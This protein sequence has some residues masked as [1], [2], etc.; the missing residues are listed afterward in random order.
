MLFSCVLAFEVKLTEANSTLLSDDFGNLNNWTIING[1]WTNTDGV[2]QGTSV[3][4]GEGLIWAGNTAWTN[5]KVTANLQVVTSGEASLVVKYQGPANFYWLGLGCWGHK[6]SISKIVGGVYQELASSGLASEVDVG[7]WYLVSAVA[8]DNKLQLFVDGAK[9]LEVQ[10]GS[11]SNGA[12]GFRDWAGT[13]QTEHLTVQSMTW[14]KTLGTGTAQSVVQTS[15]GGY[16]IASNNNNDGYLI[17]TDSSGNIQWTKNYGGTYSAAI[18]TQD[19]GYLMTGAITNLTETSANSYIYLVKTDSNG[20]MQWNTTYHPAFRDS[21]RSVVQTSDGGYAIVGIAGWTSSYAPNAVYFIKTDAYGNKQWDKNFGGSDSVPYSV[22]QTSDGG[23]A[24]VARSNYFRFGAPTYAYLIKTD[25]S[26]DQIWQNSYGNCF[27]YSVIQTLDSGYMLAG[28]TYTNA[29]N[30]NDVYL[31]KTDSYGNQLWNTTYGG[32]GDDRGNSGV[33]TGDGGYVITGYT[34][35]S[36]VGGN[37]AYLVKTD[38]SG[39]MQWQKTYGGTEDD[40]G[41]SVVQTS[42]G[43]FAIS[44]SSGSNVLLVNVMPDDPPFTVNNYDRSWHSSSFTVTLQATDDEFTSV[45]NIYYRINDGSIESVG[46]NGQPVISS[47]GTNN[48]LE[49]WSVDSLG[50]LE[51]PHNILTGIKLDKTT[52]SGSIV[53]N[54]GDAFT[55]SA[56]VTLWLTAND[57]MS[58]VSQVRYSN[59]GVWDTE[60]WEVP[61][62]SIAWT[63]TSGEGINTVYYQIKDNAGLL[64]STYSD[65]ILLNPSPTPTPTASP[66]PSPTPTA[67][68]TPSPTPTASPTPSPTPTATPTPSSTPTPIPTPT[69]SPTPSPT[70]TTTP[71]PTPTPTPIPS[72]SPSPTPT[73][74]PIVIATTTASP[75]PIPTLTPTSNPTVTPPTSSPS[76]SQISLPSPTPISQTAET[77]LY[78]YAVVVLVIAAISVT[79]LILIR[80]KR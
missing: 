48:R 43:G 56:S 1:A 71:T 80:K 35:S 28:Y 44:G 75:T 34:N 24:I 20:N 29:T 17:K 78:I 79:T 16:V 41:Y 61:T 70:P 6:Y 19:G 51:L 26:G 54:D 53:I 57:F 73:S 25:S 76:P 46:S 67:S 65:T 58:G 13:M 74:T 10:D 4:G 52:P 60:N 47:E 72:S 31:V 50:H 38:L 9:V 39:I 45:S 77:P 49:Y 36:G 37:D 18:Q 23:Y 32:T 5:Y 68:P 42:D 62:A 66:T 14:S 2:L 64:S 33:L 22:V 59:D 27:F 55:F 11:L 7:R 69:A 30:G 8:V 21:G 3:V 12:I 40:A 15:D 63:L